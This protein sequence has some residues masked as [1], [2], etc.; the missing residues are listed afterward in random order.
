[1]PDIVGSHNGSQVFVSVV[2]LAVDRAGLAPDPLALSRMAGMQVVRALVDTGAQNTSITPSAAER[3][4]LEPIGSVRVHGVGGSKLHLTYL[5]KIGLV[6]LRVNEFGLESPHIHMIDREITG[7]EFDCGPDAAFDILL[8][9]DLLS[10]GT[11]TIA[12][13]GKFKFSF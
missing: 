1:M 13:T 8:G 7:A 6:D 11:L 3:L 2:L 10:I 9:M 5:F 12:N 4:G